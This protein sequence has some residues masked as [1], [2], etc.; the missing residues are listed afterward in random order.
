MGTPSSAVSDFLELVARIAGCFEP[1]RVRG[2]IMPDTSKSHGRFTKFSAIELDDDSIGLTCVLP[3]DTF[4]ALAGF[5]SG[6]ALIGL[7]STEVAGWYGCTDVARRTLGFAAI[8]ALSQSLFRRAGYSPEPAPDSIG[9]LDPGPSDHI[10]MIGLFPPLIGPII[11]SGARL[12][13]LELDPGLVKD[14]PRLR[15]TLDPG[16]L[17]A[18]NKVVST[19]TVLLNDSLVTA[20]SACR[21]AD[22]ITLVGP[23]AGFVP[24]PLFARGVDGI[25]GTRV[26][27]PTGLRVALTSGERWGRYAQKYFIRRDRYPGIGALLGAVGHG[28]VLDKAARKGGNW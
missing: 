5:R 17:G 9:A 3:G 15:V 18:C 20:L 4:R 22:Y 1:P 7:P 12:T 25:G 21:R 6:T 14:N 13:V 19:G 23:T 27:D 16:E 28:S 11:L 24:D 2:L 26:I 10:G 8:N